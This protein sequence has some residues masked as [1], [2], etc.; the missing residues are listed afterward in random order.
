MSVS[1]AARLATRPQ[2]KY[3]AD[4]LEQI[5]EWHKK[6]TGNVL[7]TALNVRD[8]DT[9]TCEQYIAFDEAS[10][11][12]NVLVPMRRQHVMLSAAKKASDAGLAQ[13]L[14]QINVGRYALPRKSDGVVD[15][16][17]VVERK[18]GKRYV[19]QLVGGGHGSKFN[20]KMLTTGLQ[21]AAARAILQDQKAAAQLYAKTYTECARCGTAL[22]HPRSQAA[23]I[24]KHCADQWGWIW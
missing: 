1:T 2:I 16:F 20:R 12:L 9:E 15:T 13:L 21:A 23:L 6:I 8:N 17:E 18:N 11:A 3:I 7:V 14:K 10:A 5:P 24:G 4:L 22:T 19:N